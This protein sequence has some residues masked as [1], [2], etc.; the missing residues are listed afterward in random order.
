MYTFEQLMQP[1]WNAEIIYDEALT[2]VKKD[3]V[4]EAPLLFEPEEILAVTSAD[5]NQK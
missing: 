4:A 3:G 5:K 2:F 1:V